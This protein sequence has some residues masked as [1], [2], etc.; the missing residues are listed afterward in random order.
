MLA[1]FSSLIDKKTK[2]QQRIKERTSENSSSGLS[3][4]FIG[5]IFYI[6]YFPVFSVCVSDWSPSLYRPHI[7]TVFKCSR[8]FSPSFQSGSKP[9]HL[10]SFRASHI[11]C[12]HLQGP[13]LVLLPALLYCGVSV[14]P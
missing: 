13:G 6:L 14:V 8:T 1:L 9:S 2:A 10:T 4:Y 5:I 12:A 3:K 11:L 7:G